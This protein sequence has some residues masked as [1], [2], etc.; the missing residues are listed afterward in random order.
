MSGESIG[1]VEDF[2]GHREGTQPFFF[3]S[4]KPLPMKPFAVIEENASAPTLA[5]PVWPPKR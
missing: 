2:T 5:L 1:I 3:K 4:L